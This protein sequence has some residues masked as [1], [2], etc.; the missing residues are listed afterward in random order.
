[1]VV[2]CS[3][4]GE[5]DIRVGD[6]IEIHR[7]IVQDGHPIR[8]TRFRNHSSGRPFRSRDDGTLMTVPK[9]EL[10]PPLLGKVLA[11]LSPEGGLFRFEMREALPGLKVTED[12]H[13]S[14]RVF[15]SSN[16]DEFRSERKEAIIGIQESHGEPVFWETL[17][18]SG[19]PPMDRIED[20]IRTCNVFVGLYGARYSKPTLR[21]YAIAK[22]SELEILTYIKVGSQTRDPEMEEFIEKLRSEVTFRRFHHIDELR[23]YLSDDIPSAMDSLFVDC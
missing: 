15:L 6:L 17:G 13:L 12:G 21:E 7:A 23:A 1:M 22:D 8:A 16:L 2:S 19:R 5:P 18:A 4:N 11:I 10:V 14:A 3:Y 20:L 9:Q